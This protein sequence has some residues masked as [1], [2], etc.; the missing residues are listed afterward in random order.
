VSRTVCPSEADL[1]ALLLGELPEPL[2]GSVSHHLESCASCESAA[3]RLDGETESFVLTLRQVVPP[4]SGVMGSLSSTGPG[5]VP[6]PAPSPRWIADYQLLGE[7]GRGGM[8]VVYKARQFHPDR[9]VALKMILSGP[10][11]DPGRRARFLAEADAIARLQHPHVVQIYEAGQHDGLPFL[12]LEFMAGGSLA[13]R[14]GGRPQPPREAATLMEELARAV[15]YAHKQGVVHRDLKPANVLL[16]EQGYPKLADFGLAKFAENGLTTSGAILGTP[17]YM[18]PEQAAG[19]SRAVGPAADIYALGAILYELLTGRPP[20]QGATPLETLELAL[21]QEPVPPSQLQGK[22]PRDLSTICL[23]CLHKEPTARYRSA[24]ALADDLSRFLDDQPIAARRMS[25]A[26]LAWR[27]CRRNP[28]VAALLG[29]VATLLI[30]LTAVSSWTAWRFRTRAEASRAE[31]QVRLFE[32]KLAE[33]RLALTSGQPGQRFESLRLLGE[34]ARLAREEHWPADRL[35]A[36]RNDAIA[37]LTRFDVRTSRTF[38]DAWNGTSGSRAFS[39]DMSTEAWTLSEDGTVTVRRVDDGREIA[40]VNCQSYQYPVHPLLS[41]EGRFL[42]VWSSP[43]RGVTRL[44]SWD[45]SAPGR[46]AVLD[47]EGDVQPLCWSFSEDGRRFAFGRAG[48]DVAIHDPATGQQLQVLR[49][50]RK[51]ATLE[52]HPSKPLLAVAAGNAVGLH[53]MGG[54]GIPTVL[55]HPALTGSLAWSHDGRWLAVETS[56]LKMHIW[57]A[58]ARK[59]V[60]ILDGF[61]DQGIVGGFNPA[62]DLMVTRDYGAT[63]FW[64]ARTGQQ[65]LHTTGLV[66]TMFSLGG[67][68]VSSGPDRSVLTFSELADRRCFRVLIRDPSWGRGAYRECSITPDGRVLIAGLSDGFGFWDLETGMPL[69]WQPW[70][71]WSSW[72]G[73]LKSEPG[74]SLLINGPKGVTRWPVH[75]D[76]SSPRERRF[77]PPETVARPSSASCEVAASADGQVIARA[78]YSEVTIWHRD[79]PVDP[80]RLAPLKDIRYVAVSPDGRRVATA[81]HWYNQ[82]R[83]WDAETGRLEREL[84]AMLYTRVTFSPDGRW[85]ATTGEGCRLWEV[86]SWTPRTLLTQ[87]RSKDTNSVAFTPDGRLIALQTNDGIIRLAEVASGREIARLESPGRERLRSMCFSP[88]GTLLAGPAEFQAIHVWDLRAIRDELSAIGLD[89]ALPPYR[90]AAR[91]DTGPLEIRVIAEKSDIGRPV[92]EAPRTPGDEPAPSTAK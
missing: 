22:L 25:R 74:G 37:S 29:T 68:I 11:T 87:E 56:D 23:A 38:V 62:G 33:S 8:S 4:G 27:W 39:E 26:G 59:E 55:D 73:T 17:A 3:R 31:S 20:F 49:I 28:A 13:R 60:M 15:D 75:E 21:T 86:G 92:R 70:P 47:V 89:W 34:A 2:C 24:K 66:G 65:L 84:P 36:A 16:T 6:T 42:A 19:D 44:K 82:V 57:D 64:D 52:F 43:R 58:P 32:T 1:R 81:S 85:L 67:R 63:R 76:P 51:P 88:D 50:G 14:L 77:G 78:D 10:H 7:V 91:A 30:A 45:L 40:R 46:E 5:T 12:S 18:A 72:H 35:F 79:R 69:A 80:V 48:G 41:R 90:P 53:E 9:V 54:G 61:R 71:A 83:V